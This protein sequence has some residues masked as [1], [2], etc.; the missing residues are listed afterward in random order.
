MVDH[1]NIYTCF[2][3]FIVL[4]FPLTLNILELEDRVKLLQQYCDAWN[5]R[6]QSSHHCVVVALLVR[7]ISVPRFSSSNCWKVGCP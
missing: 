4:P 2:S 1:Y 3:Q 5:W 7:H 6:I